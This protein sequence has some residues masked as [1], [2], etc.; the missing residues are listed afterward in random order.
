MEKAGDIEKTGRT[1]G[2]KRGKEKK[3]TSTLFFLLSLV[4]RTGGK[5][6]GGEGKGGKIWREKKERELCVVI[7]IS[8][9]WGEGRKRRQREEK[10]ENPVP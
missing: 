4:S 5:I 9:V 10:R 6:K 1:D 7:I 3:R 8:L 2:G